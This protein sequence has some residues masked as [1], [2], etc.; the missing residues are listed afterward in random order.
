MFQ[1]HPPP[2]D[3]ARWIDAAVAIRLGAT[4]GVSRFPATPLASLPAQARPDAS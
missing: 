3:L 4:P 1:V 2:A